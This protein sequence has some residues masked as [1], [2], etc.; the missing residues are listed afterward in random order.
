MSENEPDNNLLIE[1]VQKFVKLT[2]VIMLIAL[3]FGGVGGWWVYENH[4]GGSIYGIELLMPVIIAA[5]I[6]GVGLRIY[7][8]KLF[9]SKEEFKKATELFKQKMEAKNKQG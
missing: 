1:K 2:L 3:I 7:R 4:S 9:S 5:I 6:A 8:G